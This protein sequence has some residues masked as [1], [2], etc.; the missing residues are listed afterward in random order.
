MRRQKYNAVG[1]VS[2]YNRKLAKRN[3]INTLTLLDIIYDYDFWLSQQDNVKY[4]NIHQ[5]F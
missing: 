4:F 1:T 5:D 2:T 3:K